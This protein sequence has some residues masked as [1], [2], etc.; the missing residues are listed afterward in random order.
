MVIL[1]LASVTTGASPALM[2]IAPLK[3]ETGQWQKTGENDRLEN[4]RGSVFIT[5]QPSRPFCVSHPGCRS[6]QV[7]SSSPLTTETELSL[8]DF[9]N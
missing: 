3:I 1:A 4:I 7:L 5:P 6:K 9:A 2:G 8:S